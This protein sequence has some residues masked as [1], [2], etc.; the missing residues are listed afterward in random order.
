MRRI[1]A[2]PAIARL[3]DGPDGGE[4]SPG[5][6][7]QSDEEILRY[8]KASTIPNWHAAGTNRMLPEADGG[9]VDARLRMYGVKGLRVIDCS[10]MPELP[11]V[12]IQGPVYMI[13]E[14]GAQM[15]REDWGF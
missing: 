13:G 9:V 8:I 11:D 10:I 2:H 4:V 6:G 7:V 12:N 15:I 14:K 3:T 1:L 5:A